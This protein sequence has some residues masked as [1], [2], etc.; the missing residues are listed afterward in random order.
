VL[1]RVVII[2]LFLFVLLY[3]CVSVCV[4]K[5]TLEKGRCNNSNTVRVLLQLWCGLVW[6]GLVVL[7]HDLVG[8]RRVV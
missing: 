8:E 5:H 6:F 1:A 4:K 2:A 3:V 7:L